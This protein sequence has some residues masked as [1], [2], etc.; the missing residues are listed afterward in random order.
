MKIK[1]LSLIIVLAGAFSQHVYAKEFE[2][3]RTYEDTN[4]MEI[5]R[6]A[7]EA[8]G[9]GVKGEYTI[10][11]KAAGKSQRALYL[12]TEADYR[13]PRNVSVSIHPRAFKAFRKKYGDEAQDFFVGKKIKVEG[14]ARRI[15]VQLTQ[16]TETSRPLYYY[17]T[18]IHVFKSSQI[19]IIDE[20]S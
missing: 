2:P 1:L 8:G 5:I 7:A 20:N 9:E 11:I 19:T 3:N 18:H 4:V 16:G 14:E 17:Q 12:N 6:Q 10:K 15:A 13:D